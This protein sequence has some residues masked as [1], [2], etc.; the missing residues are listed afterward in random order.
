MKIINIILTFY[1]QSPNSPFRVLGGRAFILFTFCFISTVTSAQQLSWTGAADNIS[2]FNSANWLDT[3]TNNP[4]AG[5]LASGVAIN[6]NVY[7]GPNA[8]IGTDK[9][10]KGMFDAGSGTIQFNKTNI[11]TDYATIT[12]FKSAT[13]ITLDSAI[14]LTGYVSAPTIELSGNA[15]LHLYEA[16]AI[17]V[18]TKININGEDAW[19]FFHSLT[20]QQ[21]ID[22]YA[23]QISIDGV[24]SIPAS[25]CRITQYYDGAVV[26]PHRSSVRAMYM[27]SGPNLTGVSKFFRVSYQTGNNIGPNN[28]IKAASFILKKGY[29]ATISEFQ[30]GANAKIYIAEDNDIIVNGKI[31]G[32]NDSV[33]F[34]RVTPWRWISKKGAGGTMTDFNTGWSYNWGANLAS[35]TTK[36]YVPMQWG[37]W[38][39]DVNVETLKTKPDVTSFLAFNEPD[40]KDQA[41]MT[42]TACLNNW[43]KLMQTGLRLGSPAF[44]KTDSLVKFMDRAL[45]LGYRVDFMCLHSYEK[46]TG[47][48]YVNTIYKPLW[49]KYQ[50]PIWVTEF[51]YGA[52]WNT[53]SS[54]NMLSYNN[55]NK[56]FIQKM[57]AAPFIERYALFAWS[58]PV[59]P[60]DSLFY[61]YEKLIGSPVGTITRSVLSPRG[62]FYRD[63]ESL[64]S[65]GNPLIYRAKISKAKQEII[66]AAEAADY[67][68]KCFSLMTRNN[69]GTSRR[70]VQISTNA[71][72]L[73]TAFL[74]GD[75]TTTSATT[76]S[77]L[78]TKITDNRYKLKVNNNC[79]FLS[80]RNDSV[81]VETQSSADK[82]IWELVSITGTSF[83]ALK[84]V[85]TGKFIN[86]VNNSVAIATLLTTI[87]SDDISSLRSA[88]WQITASSVCNCTDPT[89]GVFDMKVEPLTGEA[90]L[91]V[92][93]SGS[94]L[95]KESKDAFYRWYIFQETD[96]LVSTFYNQEYTY[97]KP[98]TYRIQ[99]RG[100]DYITRNTVKDYTITVT[101]PSGFKN[102]F[103]KNVTISPNPMQETIFISGIET[104]EKV[105]IYD[106]QGRMVLEQ[107]YNGSN[108]SIDFLP[109]GFYLLSCN[110]YAPVKLLKK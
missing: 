3:G 25:N 9:D 80:V 65:R 67:D 95:T 87:N 68:N 61:A 97:T 44:V 73:N 37:T 88:H 43:P 66:A 19:V 92:K 39:L 20:A 77:F 42:I 48:N 85:G 84:N 60:T 5:T 100:R 27:Y 10:V 40:G 54:D 18:D 91:T 101:A 55:G 79:L 35:T 107:I 108:I 36:E 74:G 49:D 78:F 45:A 17:S 12:G 99:V 24:A 98:G 96:T 50:I 81:V 103:E 76:E 75:G 102:A 72:K 2:L 83:V 41:N 57:D 63:F 38:N 106:T 30:N 34:V 29:V 59:L 52:P 7:F 53:T 90:P 22:K 16:D 105:V 21:V 62:I 104:G 94:K 11:R 14:V 1:T 70:K 110:G 69:D 89:L 46:R 32:K 15:Q 64:P 23:K 51:A 56:D 4:F 109:S 26:I 33:Q 8:T 93:M 31:N 71:A 13:S 86:P 47:D 6:R 58:N 28:S 82:Q